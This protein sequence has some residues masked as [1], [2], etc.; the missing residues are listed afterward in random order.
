MGVRVTA[1]LAAPPNLPSM[2]GEFVSTI[3][4]ESPRRLRSLALPRLSGRALR[5]LPYA[6]AGISYVAIGV[7]VTELLLTWFVAFAWLLAWTWGLPTIVRR[8]RR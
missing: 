3:S 8:L 7:F 4:V 5:A 6:G 1:V 2:E